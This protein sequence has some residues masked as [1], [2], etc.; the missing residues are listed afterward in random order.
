[1]PPA[2]VKRL[3]SAASPQPGQIPQSRASSPATA[4]T[5]RLATC[6]QPG[7]GRGVRRGTIRRRSL[8]AAGFR[9]RPIGTTGEMQLHTRLAS[10]PPVSV[11]VSATTSEDARTASSD[12]SA[13]GPWRGH[14]RGCSKSYAKPITA[15]DQRYREAS[16]NRSF[17]GHAL[18]GVKISRISV[19]KPRP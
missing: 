6:G 7:P 1:M 2:A 4:T 9:P 12:G 17:R 19:Q 5:A 18:R 10:A 16:R 15:K 11:V 8:S 14:E 3:R 13:A